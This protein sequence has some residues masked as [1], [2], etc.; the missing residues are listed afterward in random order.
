MIPDL[1]CVVCQITEAQAKA[2]SQ[3][4]ESI[5]TPGSQITLQQPESLALTSF[6]QHRAAQ[7][8]CGMNEEC[9]QVPIRKTRILPFF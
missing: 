8:I 1:L 6:P 3:A 5:L 4:S 7:D 2:V 9:M